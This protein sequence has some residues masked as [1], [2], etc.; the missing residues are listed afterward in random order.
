MN[1]CPVC[2]NNFYSSKSL[3]K[4]AAMLDQYLGNLVGTRNIPMAGTSAIAV[5]NK[6]QQPQ[7]KMEAAADL[8]KYY[9]RITDQV[10]KVS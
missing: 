2:G 4:T 1:D 3:A 10:R 7:A 9:A 8:I 5:I 6:N